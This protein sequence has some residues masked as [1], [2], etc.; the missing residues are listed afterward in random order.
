[1]I[2][3]I[4]FRPLHSAFVDMNNYYGTYY[5]KCWGQ[6]F[7]WDWERENYIF[8]NIFA[9]LGA[10]MYD[11][12]KKMFPKDHLFAF[13]IYL[14]AFS[15][16]SYATNGI[17]AGAAASLFLCALAYRDQKIK[18][19]LFL[20]LSLGFHH[21]MVMPIAA[22]IAALFYKNTK[23]YLWIWIICVIIAAL[24]ITYFQS[25]F[26]SMSDE[27]GSGY[28]SLTDSGYRTGFRLDFIFYSSFPIISGCYAIFRKKYQ[29]DKYKFL[30]N[31]YLLTNSIWML[32]MYA[33]FTNRIAYLSWLMLPFVLIYP[34]F[35]KEF[36]KNQYLKLNF[37]AFG[38]L[39]FTILMQVIYYA[40]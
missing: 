33:S 6:S 17:K 27:R 9:Y 36:V 1:M 20:L 31:T 25:L 15:T 18:A 8:D 2:I 13:I 35:D 32:C 39:L 22:F 24:H 30:L 3:F 14:G 12:C 29:S 23:V 26:G 19:I 34:F 28:L 16:F 21:S 7:T 37:I 10:N 38:H 40:V 4:G 11:A 5:A